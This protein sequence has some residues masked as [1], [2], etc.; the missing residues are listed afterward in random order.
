MSLCK[1]LFLAVAMLAYLSQSLAFA[2]EA[3]DAM[4]DSAMSAEHMMS[5]DAEPMHHEMAAQTEQLTDCCDDQCQCLDQSCQSPVPAI[6]ANNDMPL[7][8]AVPIG[9]L[10]VQQIIR[11]SFYLYKP[12]ILS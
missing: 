10:R 11:S 5:V 3:C 4:S 6:A 9:E 12:P 1:S 7:F 8:R 2:S